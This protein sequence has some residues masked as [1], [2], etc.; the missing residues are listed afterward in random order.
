MQFLQIA[1]ID[2]RVGLHITAYH[3]ARHGR[4]AKM[5]KYRQRCGEIMVFC[6]AVHRNQCR[7]TG[8]TRRIQAVGR[9]L[10]RDT[11]AGSQPKFKAYS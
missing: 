1:R 7:N 11:L 10:D 2:I 5:I 3:P 9:V 6:V 8:G 4:L